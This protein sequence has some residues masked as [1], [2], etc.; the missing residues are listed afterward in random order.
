MFHEGSFRQAYLKNF[1]RSKY[2]AISNAEFKLLQFIELN[3]VTDATEL[4]H[5]FQKSVQQTST[6]L[7]R[8]LDKGYLVRKDITDPSG[9]RLFE[10][11][12]PSYLRTRG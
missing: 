10:Y 1:N 7:K 11:S 3:K 8:L 12:I 6:Q 9:G 4:A 2:L 5:A